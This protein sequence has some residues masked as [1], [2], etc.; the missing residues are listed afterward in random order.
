MSIMNYTITC[1]TRWWCEESRTLFFFTPNAN[2]THIAKW[3]RAMGEHIETTLIRYTPDIRPS[4]IITE[5]SLREA[6]QRFPDFPLFRHWSS[7]G[8]PPEPKIQQPSPQ[9]AKD[10]IPF[11]IGIELTAIPKGYRQ[12]EY[13]E[14]NCDKMT[15]VYIDWVIRNCNVKDSCHRDS[16]CVE[17]KTDP[18]TSWQECEWIYKNF[19]RE[20]SKYSCFPHHP[21]TVCGGGHIHVD[22]PNE[23]VHNR[24][25]NLLYS[26]PSVPWIFLQLNDEESANHAYMSYQDQFDKWGRIEHAS[27]DMAIVS[28]KGSNTRVEFRFFEAAPTWEE[29]KL[30]ID[31]AI[32]V[33]QYCTETQNVH[34]P[35]TLLSPAQLSRITKQEAVAQFKHLCALIGFDWTH[36]KH[37]F[38]RNLYPRWQ[39][40]YNRC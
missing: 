9:L 5:I 21:D 40:G 1:D 11:K 33:C 10:T 37:L 7:V 6:Q 32:A 8:P 14:Y 4:S 39:K 19:H 12:H 13:S 31:F 20:M 26:Y 15:E 24:V 34:K 16:H 38:K 18:L 22:L 30:H 25:H 2:Q 27:K 28:S 23:Q 17:Y 35:V 3:W 36:C 29:Q